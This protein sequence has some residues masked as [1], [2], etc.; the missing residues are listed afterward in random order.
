[1]TER[2]DKQRADICERQIGKRSSDLGL[3]LGLSLCL[4]VGLFLLIHLI[5]ANLRFQY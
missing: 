5:I 2:S 4:V 1:M 3:V